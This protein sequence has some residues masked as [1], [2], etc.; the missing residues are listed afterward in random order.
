MGAINSL[1]NPRSRRLFTLEKFSTVSQFVYLYFFFFTIIRIFARVTLHV[2]Y[3]NTLYLTFERIIGTL[4]VII[5][6][7][8]TL[9]IK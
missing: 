5:V 2:S 6:Y 9:H 8:M 4:I 1:Q 7:I 3:L